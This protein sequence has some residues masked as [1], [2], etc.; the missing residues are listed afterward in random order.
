[1][2]CQMDLLR[3]RLDGEEE[4]KQKGLEI[5]AV[6]ML[7]IKLSFEKVRQATGLLID[8]IRELAAQIGKTGIQTA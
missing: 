8:R 3:Q 1:M 7:K 4:G 6:G 5:A 2:S